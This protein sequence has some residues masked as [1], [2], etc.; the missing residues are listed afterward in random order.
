MG[1]TNTIR[2]VGQHLKNGISNIAPPYEMHPLRNMG[3]FDP[4][5]HYFTYFDDFHSFQATTAVTTT[6]ATATTWICTLIDG[7]TDGGAAQAVTDEAGGVLLLTTDDADND[8]INMQLKSECVKMVTTKPFFFKARIKFLEATQNDWQLGLMVHDTTS[9]VSPQDGICFQKDDG[10][11]NID[12]KILKSGT[13]SG[14]T[15]IATAAATA[16][17]M[18]LAF[19]YTPPSYGINED[20]IRVWVTT[21]TTNGDESIDDL[22]AP[23]TYTGASSLA[24]F[25]DDQEL[26]PSFAYLNGATG[27]D[28]ISIDYIYTAFA[29][30]R[31]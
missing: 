1:K 25:C 23:T 27:V 31:S 21:G 13:D 5:H 9:L 20:S 8:G 7:A 14:S 30:G 18:T 12:F 24:G 3:Q 4:T 19:A 26:S 10:D 22:Q 2:N 15:T 6:A 29:Q 17:W 11:T 28:T 16:T